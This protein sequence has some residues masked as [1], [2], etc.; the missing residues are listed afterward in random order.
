MRTLCSWV[1]SQK[2]LKRTVRSSTGSSRIVV[3]L[4]GSSSRG[5]G[6]GGGG[7]E[8]GGGGGGWEE[9]WPAAPWGLAER[10]NWA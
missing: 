4:I 3:G 10:P 8:E 7:G 5:G 6:G 1:S 2:A 9:V